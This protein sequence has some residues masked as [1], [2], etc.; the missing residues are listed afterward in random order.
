MR[1]RALAKVVMKTALRRLRKRGLDLPAGFIEETDGMEA[2]A[3]K[4]SS[5]CQGVNGITV[6]KFKVYGAYEGEG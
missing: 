6:E 5:R 4:T 1:R 2:M 3:L